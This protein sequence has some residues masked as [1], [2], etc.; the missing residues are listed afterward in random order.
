VTTIG[1]P[2][3]P[4]VRGTFLRAV[5]P[6]FPEFVLA[7]SRSS[8]RYSRADEATLY[9]SSSVDGVRAATIAHGD[10]R[11]DSLDIVA[12]D[13][14]ASGIVDLRDMSALE[15]V[16]IDLED[17]WLPGRP[18]PRPGQH[19]GRGRCVTASSKSVRTV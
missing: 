14:E 15:A 12:M 5:D 7:G 3:M 8:G 17:A 10:A 9:L 18:S 16:G 6:R 2:F 13:V 1:L 11:P 19:R 4:A